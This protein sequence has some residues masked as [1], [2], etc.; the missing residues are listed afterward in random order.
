MK[1]Y[2]KILELEP[3]ATQ[4]EIESQYHF[5]LHA[6]HP[7]K[8]PNIDQK[9]KA[10]EKIKEINE[11]YNIVGNVNRRLIYDEEFYSSSIP[12]AKENISKKP[13]SD[14]P[15]ENIKNGN[16]FCESC[17]MPAETKYVAFFQNIGMI[18]LRRVY[19]IKGNLCKNC[20]EYYFWTFTGKTMLLGWWGFISFFTTPLI[21][22]NNLIRYI[23]CTKLKKPL[24]QIAQKPSV[25]SYFSTIGGFLLILGYILFALNSNTSQSQ[26]T[27]T[28]TPVLSSHSSP[29][30]TQVSALPPKIATP[31]KTRSNCI[32]WTKVTVDMVGKKVCVYGNVYDI[33][34]T[35]DEATRIRFSA[36]ADTFFLSDTNYTYPDLRTGECVV[37]DE[38][39]EKYG[40]ILYMSIS[41]LY[42]CESWME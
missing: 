14:S 33:Y 18:I 42:F 4:E 34:N 19:S 28:S 39:V 20:I 23:S 25:F 27:Q 8:F 22:L 26:I 6:W 1:N 16:G 15:K 40:N 30:K 13:P 38:T 36:Q 9:V 17:G 35:Q 11:A 2:Y 32:K 41:G 12:T 24:L 29:T 21:L 37:A 10:E 5:L 3:N 31:T 7:D